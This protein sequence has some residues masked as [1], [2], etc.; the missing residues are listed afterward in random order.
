ML[1]RLRRQNGQTPRWL[2]ALVS[3]VLATGV[4][5]VGILGWIGWSYL[6]IPL[7]T[8]GAVVFDRPLTI[9]PIASSTVNQGV[10]TFDLTI[11]SGEMDFNQGQTTPTWGINGNFLGP[12]LRAARGEKVRVRVTNELPEASSLHWHGMHLPAQMDGGPHQMIAPG[13]TW[14]PEWE[15]EQPAATLWYHPHPHGRTGIHV[16]R[17]LAGLFI[18]NDDHEAS[19]GLPNTYGV[20]DLPFI[21]QDRKFDSEGRF[22]FAHHSFQSAGVTGDTILVNGTVGPFFEPSREV[23]RLRLLNASNTRPYNFHF[24][25]FRT[26]TVI[27]SDGG[28]LSRSVRASSIQLSPGERAEIVVR[29]TPGETVRLQSQQSDSADRV[30]GGQDRLDIMEF[31]AQSE[32]TRGQLPSGQLA[33]LPDP[34][35]I[36]AARERSFDLSGFSIN[37]RSMDMSRVDFVATAGESELWSITNVDGQTHN[38]HVHD[39]QFRIVDINGEKPPAHLAGRKDT[40]WVPPGTTVRILVTFSRYTSTEFPYMFHCHILRHEDLGMMGQFLVVEPGQS[41]SAEDYRIHTHHPTGQHA[42]P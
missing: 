5:G 38:F 30:A 16:Y 8:R 23:N 28:L 3:I 37:G 17:G 40:V 33:I 24:E 41:T 35:Q 39:V 10:R 20:D 18:I 21:V 14:A 9:P 19:L 12:T 13:A 2:F 34:L 25:D 11:A 6:T 27:G 29:F 26:F 42:H 32:L 36:A 31:R 1:R 22:D 15:I 7:D 4:A